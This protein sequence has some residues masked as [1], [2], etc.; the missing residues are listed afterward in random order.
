MLSEAQNSIAACFLRL[1][2]KLPDPRSGDIGD[3]NW[4]AENFQTDDS[5]PEGLN[6]G[7]FLFIMA[8]LLDVRATLTEL[9]Y[10]TVTRGLFRKSKLVCTP[11]ESE[12]LLIL[13]NDVYH[14]LWTQ[15][16]DAEE[17]GTPDADS[18]MYLGGEDVPEGGEEYWRDKYLGIHRSQR[19][20]FI[21]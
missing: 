12:S 15:I 1:V 8:D 5:E 21:G 9:T 19:C 20:E 18:L 10:L 16:S 11:F 6:W 3:I 13:I 17:K 4:Y 2:R 7:A 14:P